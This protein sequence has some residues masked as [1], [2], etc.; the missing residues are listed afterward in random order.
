MAGW[1]FIEHRLAAGVVGPAGG[2]W[3]FWSLGQLFVGRSLKSGERPSGLVLLP[4]A[5][6]VGLGIGLGSDFPSCLRIGN[7]RAS[8]VLAGLLGAAQ[9]GAASRDVGGREGGAELL[10]VLVTSVAFAMVHSEQL[11]QAWGPLLVLFVVGLVLTMTRVVTRSV[12]PGLLIHVGY[13]LML[14]TC[15]IS[16][17]TISGIWSA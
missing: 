9:R 15:F 5:R 16:G 3:F 11:G 14:F 13:N 7:H 10:A 17:P 1:G 2:S 8:L 6:L 4:G 12:T